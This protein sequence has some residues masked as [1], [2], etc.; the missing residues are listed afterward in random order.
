MNEFEAK[1][2]DRTEPLKSAAPAMDAV[3]KAIAT[4]REVQSAAIDLA[5]SS[6]DAIKAHATDMMGAAKDVASQAGDRLQEKIIEQKSVG[7]DYVSNLANTMRRAAGE[8][9]AEI[10]IAGSYIRKAAARIEDAADAL[11]A[12]NFNDLVQGAQ[13][14][15]KNQPTAFLGLAVLAGFGA[16]RFLKS[17]STVTGSSTATASSANHSLGHQENCHRSNANL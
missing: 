5:N 2:Q 7:A 9:D 13:A 15:A 8:F 14:F 11:R 16:V 10:P 1:F 17:S 3:D 6:A 12:G 4:G